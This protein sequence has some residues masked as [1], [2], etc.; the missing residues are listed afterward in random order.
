MRNQ[1]IAVAISVAGLIAVAISTPALAQ[2]GSSAKK[3]PVK[4]AVKGQAQVAGLYAQ[5]GTTYTLKNNFNFTLLSARYTLEPHD[6][7]EGI[8]ANTEQ[9]VVVLDIAIKNTAKDDNGFNGEG[10]MTLV[11][12]K[13]QLYEFS[14]STLALKSMG[15][16]F[17]NTNLK[18][19][20]GLGQPGLKDP[21]EMARAIPGNA[22]I[23]KVIINVGRLGKDEQVMRYNI[24]GATKEEAGAPGD[25]RNVIAPLPDNVRDPADKSG[26]VAL[27]EG[28]G[29]MGEY[30]PSG[31]YY[32]RLDA[33]AFT[34]DKFKEEEAPAGKRYVAATVTVKYLMHDA[35]QSTIQDVKGGDFPLH[36]IKDFG[37]R[38]IQTVGL[39]QG[40]PRRRARS[41]L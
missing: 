3:P 13:G 34:T 9:K 7:Y 5:F 23:V 4:N 1:A 2:N 31:F 17:P 26:A 27:A 24:A 21:L 39:P 28:K 14:N 16:K 33:V 32:L 12:D 22:R 38:A 19:G 6:C 37:R 35:N 40:K 8:M 25:P 10:F 20:Q 11:D 30:E 41:S 29:K 15:P 36:S 18:P